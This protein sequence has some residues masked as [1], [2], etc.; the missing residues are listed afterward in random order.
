MLHFY[1]ITHDPANRENGGEQYFLIL[2]TIAL[3]ARFFQFIPWSTRD[4]TISVN[5]RTTL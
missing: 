3:S 4:N 2:V 1:L 5:W